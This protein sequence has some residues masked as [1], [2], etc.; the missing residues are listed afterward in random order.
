[1]ER[2]RRTSLILLLILTNLSLTFFISFNLN[3]FNSFN[4]EKDND[5]EQN[6]DEF[7]GIHLSTNGPTGKYNFKYYKI[8]TLN[9]SKVIGSSN[10]TN[11]PVLVSIYDADLHTKVQSSGNDI[12]F[13]NDTAWL[14]HEIELF[15]QVGN[16]TH[17]QLIAWVQIP[18]LRVSDY[19][20][21]TMYYG[22]PYLSSQENPT[23]VWDDN[24]KGIWHMTEVDAL[25]STSNQKDGTEY[26][27]VSNLDGKIGS[28]NYFEGVN[29]FIAIGNVGPEIK[30][31]E[32][33]M[34]PSNLGS[35]GS[36]ETSWKRPSATGD[37]HDQWSNPKYAFESNDSYSIGSQ[38]T[39][40]DWY[41]FSLNVPNG[42]TINGIEL[43]IEAS[44][45][46]PAEGLVALSWNGGNTYTTS[47]SKPWDVSG[48]NNETFGGT[49]N[50]WGHTW[51]SDELNNNNFRVRIQRSSHASGTLAV[52]CIYVKVYYNYDFMRIADLNGISRIE[53]VEGQLL[54]TNLP[55]T[56]TIYIDGNKQSSVSTNWQYIVITN[57]EGINITNLELGRTLTDY[58]DGIID[59]LRISDTL[60][61]PESFNTSYH[62]QNDPE[63]FCNI[64][65][66]VK[67]NIDPPIYSNLTES[68]N[69]LELGDTEIISINATD[70]SGIRQ[71]KI[72]FEG[73][74]DSM[75]NIWG[76]IWQYDSWTPSNTGNYV[77][78]IH[79]EDNCGIW[80]SVSDS[81]NVVDTTPPNPPI[82]VSAP[83]NGTYSTLVFD[84]EDGYDLSGISSYSFII[85]N[86]SDPDETPGFM[87]NINIT[88]TGSISSYLELTESFAPGT[89]YYFLLQID[90][91]GLKSNYTMGS[92]NILSINGGGNGLTV[93]DLL[94]YILGS[95]IGSVAVIVILRKRILNK[96]HPPRKKIPLKM[97][98]THINKIS[99]SSKY[100]SEK[101]KYKEIFYEE[102][103]DK[104]ELI[105]K[106][107]L[108]KQ[109]DEIKLLGEELFD[110]GAYIEAQKQ[111]ELAEQHLIKIGKKDEAAYYTNLVAEIKRLSKEHEIKLENLEY[112]KS[113]NNFLRVMEIYID[114]IKIIKNLKDVDTSKMYQHELIQIVEDG[115]LKISDLE[116]KRNKLEEQ[117][118]YYFDQNLFKEAVKLYENC[119]EISHILLQLGRVEENYNIDKFKEKIKVIKFSKIKQK[120]RK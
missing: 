34:K 3:D 78:T 59:E 110:E 51:T 52:D 101:D 44:Y 66:E 58:F 120:K 40:Q 5:L 62:N 16:G 109:L 64:S 67:F 112:E 20:N 104:E 90:G 117:A 81:I 63:T 65:Q 88:Y 100:V 53:I 60:R 47:E 108:E 24:Y 61:I 83:T 48:D 50:D 29:E 98:L 10:Y 80:N 11:F 74:N 54:T 38:N 95:V 7:K 115:N 87:Y 13:A 39:Y 33:W 14:N 12:A 107:D 119:E 103:T 4:S 106:P 22:N 2:N 97:I 72:E 85:D 46:S 82:I 113:S 70:L 114:L 41:N 92:F 89:Y 15:D 49:A 25:D 8:I 118:K 76:D 23:E 35:G 111:F 105:E 73:T 42:A 30:T 71:V 6:L 56:T 93:L 45:S 69:T 79:I 9:H 75:T 96:I 57:T 84:W 43:E 102:P 26:G 86:E 18:L 19:T 99:A 32:F 55:D 94:P 28:S 77:Y 21:I 1:M 37:D 31:I 116:D 36:V 17:A 27:G 91:A 68:S